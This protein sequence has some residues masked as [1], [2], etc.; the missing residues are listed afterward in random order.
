MIV[1]TLSNLD[2]ID[3]PNWSEVMLQFSFGESIEILAVAKRRQTYNAHD[4][5]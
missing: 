2:E 3:P 1:W 5:V 4:K